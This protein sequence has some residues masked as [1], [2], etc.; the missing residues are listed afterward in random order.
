MYEGRTRG[1][2]MRYTYDDGE[3]EDEDDNENF[4]DATSNRRSA[5]QSGRSTP[6]E[7]GPQYTASG[8]QVKPRQGGEYGASL[9]SR[10][11]ET[12]DELG[13]N[14]SEDKEASDSEQPVRGGARAGRATR[15]A[16]NGGS[17]LKKRQRISADDEDEGSLDDLSDDAPPTGEE[18]DS[19]ANDDGDDAMPDADEESDLL[20]DEDAEP[21]SLVITLKTNGKARDSGSSPAAEPKPAEDSAALGALK[22]E[23]TYS[24]AIDDAQPASTHLQV[25]DADTKQTEYPTPTSTV[26]AATAVEKPLAVTALKPQ[27]SKAPKPAESTQT[28]GAHVTET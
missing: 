23:P 12:P 22:F 6:A 16:V 2:R 21:K 5:R 3:D 8:R 4:S 13:P 26:T 24:V 25:Q 9:L 11:A 19:Q 14:Y 15:G 1:K 20:E 18:W 17:G 10:S 7:S 27:Q 28:N